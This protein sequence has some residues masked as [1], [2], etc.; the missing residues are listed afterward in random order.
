MGTIGSQSLTSP[1]R[2]ASCPDFMRHFNTTAVNL[3]A[4]LDDL[5][6][7]VNATRPVA[8]KLHPFAKRLRGFAHDAV[9]TV[10][11][12]N[13]DHQLARARTTT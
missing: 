11:D 13:V 4:T 2:S 7:L 5:Q 8:R 6:P 9:P 12:L 10:K 1:P 3:R